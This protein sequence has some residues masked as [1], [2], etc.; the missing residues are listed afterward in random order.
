MGGGKRILVKVKVS[1]F[2]RISVFYQYD[3]FVSVL[4]VEVC[5]YIVLRGFAKLSFIEITSYLVIIIAFLYIFRTYRGIKIVC[6]LRI[7]TE[8]NQ[9]LYLPIKVNLF[10]I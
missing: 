6:I 7:K 5:M 4:P 8:V 10:S 1:Y 2:C 9:I 3:S